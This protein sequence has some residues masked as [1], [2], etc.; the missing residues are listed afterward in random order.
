MYMPGLYSFK[1]VANKKEHGSKAAM[2]H[3]QQSVFWALF[4]KEVKTIFRTPAFVSNCIV[5]NFFWP[6]LIV[7]VW[8]M[9]KGNETIDS[10]ISMYHNGNVMAAIIALVVFLGMAALTTAANS[11]ASSAFTREGA[12]IDFMKY[13]PVDY[14]TQIQVKGLISIV[15]S[16]ISYLI[17][18][19]ILTYILKPTAGQVVYYI[20][21]GFTLVFFITCLGIFLDSHH[22]K[23]IWED[24]LNALRGNLNVFF[25]MAFAILATGII[26]GAGFLLYLIPHSTIGFIYA[27]YMI[28][29]L[30]LDIHMY[31][32]TI[33]HVIKNLDESAS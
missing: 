2:T 18:V 19:A 9:Q 14:K 6:I 16:F 10:F 13:I 29:L 12:H 28:L 20:I 30:L 22:P 32:Y 31:D 1:S 23:L 7:I 25:N 8:M 33:E 26:V 11:L 27:I 21:G 3:S 4:K 17:D 24:E 5:V 15:I